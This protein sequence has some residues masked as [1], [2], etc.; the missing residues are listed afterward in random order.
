MKMAKGKLL[1]KYFNF[2]CYRKVSYC[3]PCREMVVINFPIFYILNY[4]SRSNAST[5]FTSSRDGFAK[6][7]NLI[8]LLSWRFFWTYNVVHL[9]ARFDVK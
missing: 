1:V 9:A 4:S 3:Y 8:T 6:S 2:Q 7:E 5:I